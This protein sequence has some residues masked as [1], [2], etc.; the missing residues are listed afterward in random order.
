MLRTA[1]CVLI[2]CLRVSQRHISKI[3]VSNLNKFGDKVKNAV[4]EK[5][6]LQMTVNTKTE[7][8]T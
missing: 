1:T 7:Q 8:Q 2:K 5:E 6:M 3:I 4:P